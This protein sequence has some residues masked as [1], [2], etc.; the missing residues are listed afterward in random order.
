SPSAVLSYPLPSLVIAQSQERFYPQARVV[1]NLLPCHSAA[2]MP[3]TAEAGR[4]IAFTPTSTRGAWEDRWNTKGVPET[5]ALLRQVARA[6]GWS[7][8]C[9]TDRPLEDAL[10]AKRAAGLVVDD[11][12]TGGYHLSG[13][14]GLCLG[15]PVL[16]YLDERTQRVLRFITG[17]DTSPFVNVRLE[18]ARGV[19]ES[20][21]ANPEVAADLGRAGRAWIDRYWLPQT[22]VRHFDEA[23]RQLLTDPGLVCRQEALRLDEPAERFFAIALPD[24]VY[25]ARAARAHAALPLGARV[26]GS[27]RQRGRTLYHRCRKALPTLA[28]ALGA[29]RRRAQ[30]GQEGY[31]RST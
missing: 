22:L 30:G 5:L 25:H 27:A 3:G 18:D 26:L 31:K 9:I 17:A 13:L 4:S 12:V 1:P 24:A 15:K 11:L 6:T 16:A 28:R 20:L 10:A 8:D 2:L 19:L 23:Y 7:V 29:L 21:C 14:E